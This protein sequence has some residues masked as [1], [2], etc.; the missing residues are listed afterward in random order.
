M[1][2]VSV[3]YN[4]LGAWA[5]KE[6]ECEF[7]AQTNADMPHGYPYYGGELRKVVDG[8][9]AR[10]RNEPWG[11]TGITRIKA[12]TNSLP[13]AIKSEIIYQTQKIT[14]A[15]ATAERNKIVQSLRTD[16]PQNVEI[17]MTNINTV[18][19]TPEF[20][21]TFTDLSKE[22]VKLIL[23]LQKVLNENRITD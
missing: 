3:S 20:R 19:Q 8:W 18:E 4:N 5:D 6:V 10:S 12:I 9:Q 23:A 1:I 17:W 15:A 11:A 2:I 13:H 14:H 22:E 16:L 21:V 7:E